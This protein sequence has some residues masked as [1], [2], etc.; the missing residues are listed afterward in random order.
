[1]IEALEHL[2]LPYDFFIPL[3][4]RSWHGL[5]HDLACDVP[6]HHQSGDIARGVERERRVGVGVGGVDGGRCM[7]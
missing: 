5:H 1:M 7:S 2:Q 4:L 3:N 6:C